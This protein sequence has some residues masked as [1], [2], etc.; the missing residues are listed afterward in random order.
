MISF[1]LSLLA[2][3]VGYIVYGKFVEKTFGVDDN[4]KTPAET[5]Q[6]QIL[7]NSFLNKSKRKVE[8]LSIFGFFM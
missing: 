8:D 5:M 6:Y 3:V 1:L 4:I 2:L 7:I